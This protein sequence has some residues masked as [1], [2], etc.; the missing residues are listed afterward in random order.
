MK[1]CDGLTEFGNPDAGQIALARGVLNERANDFGVGRKTG[2]AK[3]Q[4]VYGL[5]FGPHPANAFVDQ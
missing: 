1:V 5:A 3:S 4:V 2:L